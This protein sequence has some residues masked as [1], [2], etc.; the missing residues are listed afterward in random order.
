MPGTSWL[1]GKLPKILPFSQALLSTSS[2]QFQHLCS[3]TT[4]ISGFYANPVFR[5][6]STGTGCFIWSWDQHSLVWW[7]SYKHHHK[8]HPP[9]LSM[10]QSTDHKKIRILQIAHKHCPKRYVG[11]VIAHCCKTWQSR[12]PN[13]VVE[14]HPHCNTL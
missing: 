2:D 1:A 9:Y 5:K 6:D 13:M 4:K 11:A 14:G 3:T 8:I 12:N 10:L 7:T